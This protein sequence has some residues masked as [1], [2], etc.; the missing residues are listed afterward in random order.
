MYNI[1]ILLIIETKLNDS[2][3]KGQ[4]CITGFHTPFR[5]DRNDKGAGYY[6]MFRNTY[7]AED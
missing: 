2:F 4:F 6:F 5:K 3:P 1:D 7:L